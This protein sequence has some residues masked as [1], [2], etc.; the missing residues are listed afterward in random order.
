MVGTSLKTGN[1]AI[2]ELVGNSMK[3]SRMTSGLLMAASVPVFASSALAAEFEIQPRASIGYQYWEY[4]RDSAT[5]DI[6][7]EADYIFGGLGVT[8]QF[9][10]FFVDL[11]GQTNLT[12]GDGDDPNAGSGRETDVN[13]RELN[14]TGGYAF[15]R[16]ITAFGG[17]KY[18][19]IEIENEFNSG[20]TIDVDTSYFGPFAG[21]S[22]SYPVSGIG[23]VSLSGSLAFLDGEEEIDN[24]GIVGSSENDGTS[25][26]YSLGLTWSG[27]FSPL[28][29]SLPG[30]GYGAGLD[31]S[32]YK[33][34][35]DGD[36]I[37]DVDYDEKT[38][39][40]RVDLR[41]RF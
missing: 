8:G 25:I 26:G 36:G 3:H 21:V 19:E 2:F 39:R 41:Y 27:N 10:Q 16:Y 40:A 1:D 6:N 24:S 13:R 5:S 9:G 14:V 7:T 17:L 28:T 37:D 11:Y 32:S 18:A 30:L 4:N 15:N 33:F 31:Y 34:E 22:L 29:A 12:E 35:S 23:A 38:F 20:T